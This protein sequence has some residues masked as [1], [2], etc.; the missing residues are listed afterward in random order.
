MREYLERIDAW[1][2]R[3]ETVAVATVVRTIGSAPRQVGAQ[4]FVASGGG[5]AGSVSGGCVEGAVFTACQEAIS[6][7][8]A[9]LLHFGVSDDDAWAVGL[10]CGGTIEVLVEVLATPQ[11]QSTY[12][13]L[14][15]LITN[16]QAVAIVT[17]IEGG[18]TIGA[19]LLLHP[20]GQASGSLGNTELTQRACTEAQELLATGITRS[21]SYPAHD[22]TI[23]VQSFLPPP[24]LVMIG[25]VHIAVALAAMARIVGFHTVVI[26][27]RTAF[28]NDERFAHVDELLTGWPDEGLAHY[29]DARSAVAVLTHDPKL[30]DP[31]LQVALASTARYIGA[32]GSRSTHQKRLERLRAAGLDETRLAR[33]HGPIGLA[34][35]A[36]TPEEIGVSILAQIIQVYRA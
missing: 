2:A 34:L 11:E 7:G 25:G 1:L 4:M 33:I 29:L 13:T 35:G 12:H 28:A 9:R 10:A 18:E 24:T 32:L 31:A 3:G 22:A 5:I 14:S 21:L 17:L 30:D 6:T 16:G 36:K 26:D 27:P 19:R 20:N 8:Q 23:F 15:E